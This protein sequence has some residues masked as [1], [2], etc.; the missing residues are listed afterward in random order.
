VPAA[1][2]P[3]SYRSPA[4]T[5]E[6]LA[7]L[8]RGFTLRQVGAAVAL[9]HEAVRLRLRTRGLTPAAVRAVRCA[10]CGA[11]LRAARGPDR[12]RHVCLRPDCRRRDQEDRRPARRAARAAARAA[13]PPT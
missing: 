4:S 5:D 6:I 10:Y 9:S 11:L 13:R 1:R 2:R 7:L 3:A 8:A 12:T